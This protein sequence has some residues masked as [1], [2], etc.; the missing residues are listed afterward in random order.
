[1]GVFAIGDLHACPEELDVLLSHLQPGGADTLVFLG[2]YVDR[3]PQARTLIE[4][5]LRLREEGPETVFLRGNH[6]DMLLHYL[7]FPGRYADAYLAN[8]GTTTLASYGVPA[9]VRGRAASALLPASHLQFLL[10]LRLMHEYDRFLFVHAGIRPGVALA[11]QDA[12]DLLWIREEFL[13]RPHDL[14]CTVVYGHT[15][16]RDVHL[17]LPYYIGIDTGLV[18][19]NKLSCLDVSERRLLQVARG[20]RQVVTRDLA[21]EFTAAH[22]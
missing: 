4:R 9:S 13:V 22:L 8:G 11:D 12:E 18:Y 6:E 14:S 15:P 10:D 19:G 16:Q 5:L 17:A 3:G 21:R 7:G 2:D 20:G 1:M